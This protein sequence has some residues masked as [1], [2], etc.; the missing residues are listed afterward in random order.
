MATFQSE[1]PD[2]QD[3]TREFRPYDN[4]RADLGRNIDKA[5]TDVGKL[6]DSINKS[7]DANVMAQVDQGYFNIVSP[8]QQ[9][10]YQTQD[11]TMAADSV[12]SPTDATRA[13]TIALKAQQNP[14][15]DPSV[16]LA[17][18]SKQLITANPRYTKEIQARLQDLSGVNPL[19]EQYKR[20]THDQNSNQQIQDDV[21]KSIATNAANNGTAVYSAD[22]QLDLDKTKVKYA[23]D[24]A[25]QHQLQLN[26]NLHE[27]NKITD[28]EFSSKT[29]TTL[30]K[31]L[32]TRVDT[33]V[34][35][36]Y[37]QGVPNGDGT[38]TPIDQAKPDQIAFVVA[39]SAAAL[40]LGIN[41]SLA[42]SGLS[43]TD[44]KEIQE[45]TNNYV[46]NMKGL[47]D[48]PTKDRL[49]SIKQQ[50][51]LFK[52]K[53]D[54]NFQEQAPFLAAQKE[55]YGDNAFGTSMLEVKL[56]PKAMTQRQKDINNFFGSISQPVPPVYQGKDNLIRQVSHNVDQAAQDP[57][58]LSK[59]TPIDVSLTSA[60]LIQ[61]M[62]ISQKSPN[63]MSNQQ[64]TYYSNASAN[65]AHYGQQLLIKDSINS[66]DVNNL[67]NELTRPSWLTT[68]NQVAQRQHNPEAAHNTGTEVS[69]YLIKNLDYQTNNLKSTL[70]DLVQASE[71]SSQLKAGETV[72]SKDGQKFVQ[73]A[74]S[75]GN[76]VNA[77]YPTKPA[78]VKVEVNPITQRLYVS[79]K[80][81]PVQAQPG[82]TGLLSRIAYGVEA[83]DNPGETV[84]AANITDK[85]NR[86]IDTMVGLKKYTEYKDATDKEYRQALLHSIIGTPIEAP[87]KKAA[88]S[89]TA[90][91][92]V[93]P[94]APIMDKTTGKITIPAVDFIDQNEPDNRKVIPSEPPTADVSTNSVQPLS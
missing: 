65:L 33:A 88:P 83:T 25:D 16:D 35:N 80:D 11:A 74:D 27:Q 36:L 68:F 1:L 56:D 5:S 49:A 15:Y 78:D 9:A 17:A 93:V 38:F 61:G 3:Q 28:E 24:Q 59:I 6:A 87:T 66:S 37:S 63:T 53:T 82:G 77:P 34:T 42:Q 54:M 47:F 31:T 51:D 60:P 94:N 67:T 81:K 91:K 69:R 62:R 39:Q 50:T 23:A 89:E 70:G 8:D 4:G 13:S 92:T 48:N 41:S 29:K 12:L 7:S 19:A 79:Y 64:D 2:S 26:K 76:I 57:R 22:G 10:G 72:I 18:L 40:K 73:K 75:N 21:N 86:T 84:T 43:A 20:L 46:D 71:D 58:W 14:N 45:Q 32:G 85:M 30:I 90:S 55:I 44:A 52:S